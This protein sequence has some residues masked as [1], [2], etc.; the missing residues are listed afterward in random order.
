MGI[1]TKGFS[2]LVITKDQEP[3]PSVSRHAST[4]P[5]TDPD[6][7]RIASLYGWWSKLYKNE[8]KPNWLPICASYSLGGEK[9]PQIPT[10]SGNGHTHPFVPNFRKLR[11]VKDIR[12]G[13]YFDLVAEVLIFILFTR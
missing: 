10:F 7:N 6:T 3:R 9:S 8:A 13:C 2:F 5:L 12:G 1:N 4:S 11:E